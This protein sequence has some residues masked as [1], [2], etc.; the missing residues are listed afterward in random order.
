MKN[1][2]EIERKYIIEMPNRES[3]LAL[4]FSESSSILQ[5]YL[6]SEIGVTHRIRS[7]EYKD[8]VRFFE[9]VKMRIDKISAFEDEKEVTEAEF[10]EKSKKIRKGSKPLSKERITFPYEE[11]LIEI[12]LYPEWKSTA[13][14]E[15]E[16]KSHGET[17]KIPGF[18]KIIREVTGEKKYTNSSLAEQFPSEEK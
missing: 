2:I 1:N 16:L 5:I 17:P 13:I 6:E 11:Y 8:G 7:R 10:R 14:M 4:P 18:I 15:I 3:L 9:T 12:D